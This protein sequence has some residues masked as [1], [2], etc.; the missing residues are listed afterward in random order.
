MPVVFNYNY[1]C[2]REGSKAYNDSPHVTFACAYE[3]EELR[4]G[5]IKME[6]RE[7]MEGRTRWTIT[8]AGI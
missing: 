5:I 8:I 2:F 3:E 1:E 4:R 7:E 6:G